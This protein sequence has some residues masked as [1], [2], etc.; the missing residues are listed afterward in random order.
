MKEYFGIDFGTTNSAVVGRLSQ[1]ITQYGDETGQPFPSLVAVSRVTGQV[2][3]IGRD[4]WKNR[5]ALSESCEILSSAKMLLGS[6]KVWRIGPETWNYERVTT[7]VLKGL[8]TRV[9]DRGGGAVLESAF[10]AI[11]VG[12]KPEKRKA[13]RKAAKDA[14]IE[15]RGFVSEPTAAVFRNFE[16]VYQWPTVAVFDWGGGTLD[17]S[18]VSIRGDVVEEIATLS[19]SVAGDTLDRIIAEWAHMK[20]LRYKNLN[21]P[22]FDGMDA[23]YRDMLLSQCE[24]AKRTLANEE[25]AEITITRYGEFGVVNLAITLEEFSELMRPQIIEAIAALE[26]VVQNQARLSFDQ[27]GCIIMVGGSS[28]LRGLRESMDEKGWDCEISLPV[29]SEW[30]VADGS[31]ILSSTLGNYIS[32]QSIGIRLSDNTVYSVINKGQ[33][34]SLYSNVTTFGLV[35]DS[36]NARFVFVECRDGTDAQ[37]L[38]ME[39]ILGYLSVPTYGFSNEP[40]RLSS[41]FDED[42][43]LH[44]T[45]HSQLRDKNEQRTWTYGNARFSYQLPKMI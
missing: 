39:K 23:R 44:I 37:L 29:S 35:E 5:L 4:A 19:Q 17:I 36:D 30:Y 11:P 34:T 9:N 45:A 42:L 18:V 21:G 27:L 41:R 7:E 38:S 43:L 12:F 1:N 22:P 31:A 25:L 6:G 16:Q 20:I 40:I 3:A 15:V 10:F 8:R 33:N 14:G 13:L 2:Q 32:A 28:K 24:L 26:E